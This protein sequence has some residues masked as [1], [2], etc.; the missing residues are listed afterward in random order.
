MYAGNPG[1]VKKRHD[2]SHIKIYDDRSGTTGGQGD[3]HGSEKG[4]RKAP[5]PVCQCSGSGTAG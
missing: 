2:K 1:D 3:P 4:G 5:G